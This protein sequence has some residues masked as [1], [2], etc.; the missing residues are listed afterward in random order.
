MGKGKE[1]TACP[2]H[3][4]QRPHRREHP[5]GPGAISRD[6]HGRAWHP[7]R[8]VLRDQ[9]ERA[10][11]F[12]YQKPLRP[13]DHLHAENQQLPYLAVDL[14]IERGGYQPIVVKAL[15]VSTI[16][17][18]DRLLRNGAEAAELANVEGWRD[19]RRGFPVPAEQSP[20]TKPQQ[21]APKHNKSDASMTDAPA[22]SAES[23]DQTQP[24]HRPCS[25][26]K[27]PGI[28]NAEECRC[29]ELPAEGPIPPG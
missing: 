2:H 9:Q 18:P 10:I 3:A 4:R 26:D 14:F 22:A 16:W 8:A 6:D 23:S 12:S 1:L 5:Q 7:G 27:G 15:G 25:A 19:Y 11:Q 20:P 13:S 21:Q 17:I 24:G 28:K 29:S